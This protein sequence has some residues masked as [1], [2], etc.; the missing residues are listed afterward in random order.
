MRL[1]ERDFKIITE[2]ENTFWDKI[3]EQEKLIVNGKPDIRIK[4][5][6]Y[7]KYPAAVR[8]YLSLFPN[9]FLDA[10]ELTTE[11]ESLKNKLEDFTSLLNNAAT[12]ERNILDY[13]KDKRAYFIIGSI[14]KSNYRF[15]HHSAYIFPEFRLPPNFQVDFLVIGKNSDGYH[16]IFIELEN[17]YGQITTSDG[18]YGETI[19]KGIKQIEEW[20]MW[21]EANYSHLRLVFEQALGMSEKLPQEFFVFD[22][23]RIHY[24]IFAGRRLDYS[25]KTYRLQR[26][27]L[28][29]RKLNIFHYDNLIDFA[30]ETIGTYSY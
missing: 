19:R 22:K 7:T 26:N 28:E 5:N 17:A 15:G 18:S 12:K 4:T 9:N 23:T 29:Q 1:Y 27:N 6:L 8:Y 3:K 30:N 10:I 2:E 14:L 16:F 24:A 11:R 20:E 25:K 13:I 21:L